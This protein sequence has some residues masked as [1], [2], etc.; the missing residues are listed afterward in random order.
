LTHPKKKSSHVTQ[1]L[2]EENRKYADIYSHPQVTI[3]WDRYLPHILDQLVFVVT[4]KMFL[5]NGYMLQ[6]A[7]Y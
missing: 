2:F 3:N 7:S 6:P 1:K 5:E 4:Y